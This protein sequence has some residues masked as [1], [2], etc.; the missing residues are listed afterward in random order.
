MFHVFTGWKIGVEVADAEGAYIIV[1]MAQVVE[2]SCL[3]AE[4]GIP[5]A[6]EG[7]VPSRHHADYPS[8]PVVRLGSTVEVQRVQ[9]LLDQEP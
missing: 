4:H 2:L 7:D 8:E 5:H 3:L 9:D 6:V 1:P